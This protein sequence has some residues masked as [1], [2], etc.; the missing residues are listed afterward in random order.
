[1]SWGRPGR[2]P[3]SS[4][5]AMGGRHSDHT[6]LRMIVIHA[7]NGARISTRSVSSAVGGPCARCHPRRAAPSSRRHPGRHAT[8]A[9]GHPDD[10]AAEAVLDERVTIPPP[11]PPPCRVSSTTRTRPV[12]SASRTMSSIGNGISQR[13]STMRL[14][15]PSQSRALTA[16]DAEA[17]ALSLTERLR[18]TSAVAPRCEG[19]GSLRRS[20][21]SERP[22]TTRNEVPRCDVQRSSLTSLRR[23]P[24][25]APS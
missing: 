4:T 7:V 15:A 13:T 20:T 3:G 18:R 16:A 6:S 1:M 24:R 8:V 12:A 11:T 9:A 22:A 17:P 25:E 10:P 5:G 2:R 14:R 21:S 19:L 23:G